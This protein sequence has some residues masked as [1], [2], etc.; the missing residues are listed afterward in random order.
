MIAVKVI[1]PCQV[2]LY[3]SRYVSG[4]FVAGGIFTLIITTDPYQNSVN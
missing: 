2:G 4:R 3:S 1:L